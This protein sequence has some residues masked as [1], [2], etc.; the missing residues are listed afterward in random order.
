MYTVLF[1]VLFPVLAALAL[2]LSRSQ[3]MYKSIIRFA[4]AVTVLFSI[5]FV[6]VNYRAVLTVSVGGLPLEVLNKAFMVIELLMAAYIVYAGFKNR[7]Y[8]VIPLAVIQTVVV[9]WLEMFVKMPDVQYALVIDKLSLV[10]T[11][12]I[13][14]VGGLIC[15]YSIN[16]MRDYHERHA[17]V[18]DRR[19]M[20][21]AVL[22]IFLSAMFGLVFCNNLMWLLFC[23]EVTS[24]C[25]FLLIGYTKTQE[26]IKNAFLALTMNVGGGLAFTAG[27]ALLVARFDVAD[28]SGMLS[29]NSGAVL[30]LIVFLLCLAG[31]TKAAQLPFSSWLLGA[32]IAP[33]P[34]SAL[35]HSSTMV[36]A[37]VY[38]VIRMSHFLG[39]NSVGVVITLLG[40]F[41]FIATA[42][43]AV[44]QSD[45]KRI[46]AY[47]T[48]SNLGLIV[49][50]AGIN[51]P[52]SLWAAVMLI[53]FHAAA[54]A[55]LFLTVGS[56]EHTIGSR[57]VEDMDG[58]IDVSPRLAL[59]FITGIAVMFIAPFGMLVSKWA[60]M[61]AFI[62]S[63]NI[64]AV[65]I[66]AFGSSITMFFWA[67]WLGKII[68]A[69]H[70]SKDGWRALGADEKYALY[71]LTVITI[72]CCLGFPLISGAFVNPFIA[73]A[74][75]AEAVPI[76]AP[77]TTLII[78]MICILFVLPVA[79]AP[80]F[81]RQKLKPGSVYMAGVNAGDNESFDASLGV[82][83]KMEFR[84][85]YLKD[86][87]GEAMLK[88]RSE[89]IAAF[90]L[91]VG[92][93]LAIGGLFL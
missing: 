85:W 76:G 35:L 91:A 65:L 4:S 28:L 64:L 31:V 56:T 7:Q 62:D 63:N 48:V 38:L 33:T 90:I 2:L 10:M 55:L 52:A 8:L 12:V 72:L 59:F 5:Y 3:A 23:W 58:L 1:L 88:G 53:I 47:S 75:L 22:F 36:K 69:A 30:L 26:A 50:C 42:A 18:P 15:L 14:V 82:T 11:L 71:A 21:Y 45:A 92:L 9:L 84:N 66:L 51:T 24:F 79:L 57:S 43:L 86:I 40:A 6:A 20:F 77:D 70:K 89:M 17:G 74:G 73:S 46:L 67:K 25:S 54:K 93:C 39:S 80:I 61:R 78:A 60:A 13:G 16:Y 27:I 44:S 32:M 37:G 29:L 41:T 34:T 87:F 19:P 81:A 83:Q 49:A 68:E